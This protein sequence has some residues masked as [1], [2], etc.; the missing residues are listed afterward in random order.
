MKS[1][2]LVVSIVLLSL[3]LFKSCSKEEVVDGSSSSTALIQVDTLQVESRN[4][5][6]QARPVFFGTTLTKSNYRIATPTTRVYEAWKAE[7]IDTIRFTKVSAGFARIGYENNKSFVAANYDIIIEYKNQQRDTLFD[8]LAE[9][10]G[11]SYKIVPDPTKDLVNRI[12]ARYMKWTQRPTSFRQVMLP[13]LGVM[14]NIHRWHIHIK[15]NNGLGNRLIFSDELWPTGETDYEF[16]LR[17]I[18]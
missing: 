17:N 16:L 3:L 13:Y 7:L 9:F 2:L 14:A 1:K 15:D 10:K 5:I 11:N 4:G 18:P 6:N 12:D 8:H